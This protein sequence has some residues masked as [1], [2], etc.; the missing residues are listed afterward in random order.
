MEESRIPMRHWCYAFWRACT[1]KKGA[2]ALEIKRH[3]GLTYKSSLFLMHRI[4]LAMAETHETPLAGHVEADETYV[5]GYVKGGWGG[6]GKSP[7]LAVIQRNGQARYKVLE[8]V[9]A[10]NLRDHIDTTVDKTRSLLHTDESKL[11]RKPGRE[12]A[13]G[14]RAVHHRMEEYYRHRDQAGVNTCESAFAVLKRGLMGIYHQVSKHHLHR[15]VSEFEFRWNHR[16]DEDGPRV[17]AAIQ[18]AEGK[19]LVY[20]EPV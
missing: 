11:Y 13:G 4:K 1:S 3:T 16:K 17:A 18:G 20:R 15:Y 10:A 8:K 7:V 5:G 6:K 9:T 14:H 2:A 19:R 12:F